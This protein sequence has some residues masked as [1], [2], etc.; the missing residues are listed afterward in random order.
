MLFFG[1]DTEN[2]IGKWNKYAQNSIGNGIYEGTT[3]RLAFGFWLLA[4]GC[5]LLAVGCWLLA[6]GCWLLA[7]GCWLLAGTQNPELRT[8]NPNL[9]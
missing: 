6:F 7:V 1:K 4:V 9:E 8:R 3:L 2:T 5:W